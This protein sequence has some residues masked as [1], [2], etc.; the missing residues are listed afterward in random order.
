VTLEIPP[1]TEL[2]GYRIESHLARGGMGVL[3]LAEHLR[4]KRKVALKVLAPEIARDERFRERFLAEAEVAAS[5][6]H[7]NLVT[8]FDA[9]E[10]AGQLFIAMRL[11]DGV[12]LR[13]LIDR[14]GALDPDRAA[15]LISQVARGLDA[16]HARGLIHRDVKP[17]NILVS[18]NPDGSEHAY[19][20]DFG[21][22][23]RPDQT[24]GLTRTGQFMG[25]VDYAAPEQFEGRPLDARTDVYSLACVAFE[26]LT[27][28]VP[29]RRDREASVMYAHLKEPAPAPSAIRPELGRAVDAAIQK[30]MA[31]AP[32]MRHL[33]TGDFSRHLDEAILP[34]PSSG[35]A[36]AP[37][38]PARRRRALIVAGFA[39]AVAVVVA[40]II[41]MEG[42]DRGP[43]TA[44]SSSPSGSP[45]LAVV[46]GGANARI[47]PTTNIVVAKA[48]SIGFVAV[49]GGFVWVSTSAGLEKINPQT[50]KII[51]V[52]DLRPDDMV[53]GDGYLWATSS[54]NNGFPTSVQTEV[55]DDLYRIEPTTNGVRKLASLP[56]RALPVHLLFIHTVAIGDGGVWVA[57]KTR[58]GQGLIL[59]YDQQTGNEVRRVLLPE[60][61][62]GLAFGEG[63]LWIRSNAPV[64]ASVARID[65]RT[66]EEITRI[67]LSSADALAVGEG[68]VWVSDSSDNVV[69][70]ID[71][72]TNT[73]AGQVAGEFSA[74]Q[75]IEVGE[76]RVW[77][78]NQNTCSV[79][80]IDPGTSHVVV[81]IPIPV[82]TQDATIAD[83]R[84]GVWVGGFR[85]GPTGCTP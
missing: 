53:F 39:L 80:R 57:L 81:T 70:K 61:P 9:G 79:A 11:I 12:D 77:V 46:G 42:R 27:G 2:A 72:A 5:L 62:D 18:P 31:K 68:A 22:T 34:K 8:V 55:R 65:P 74:P 15:D 35:W 28:Q 66:G 36:P 26:C 78:L 51:G 84:E 37:P 6:D 38:S 23:K 3:Y 56:H 32:G 63:S 29:F 25:S 73:L 33:T 7:P 10:A 67:P 1:G 50:G 54:G 75:T 76:G 45:S 82:R 71:P 48:G 44:T 43:A 19:L 85:P 47:D 59:G 41:V 13:A 14:E 24:T 58:E 16:A 21:L 49:G 60:P 17:A 30:A 64:G 4:L 20:T 83:G 69:V 40:V 52:I